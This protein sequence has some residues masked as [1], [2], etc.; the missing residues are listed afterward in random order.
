MEK[1]VAELKKIVRFKDSTETG[2][3]V[4]VASMEPQM[5]VYALV[6]DIVRDETKRDEWWRLTMQF[7]TMPPQEVQWTLRTP[8][9]TGMELFT[10]EGNPRFVK[11]ID[12]AGAAP[13]PPQKSLTTK[14]M[15]PQK[16]ASK[17]KTVLRLVK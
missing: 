16:A 9:L 2:D 10:M 7:L 13:K 14:K 17:K 12:F 1:L 8:Q 6:T 15:T 5:L 4:L 3:L 11:A